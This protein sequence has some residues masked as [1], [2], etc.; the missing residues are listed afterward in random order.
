MPTL[1]EALRQLTSH[2]QSGGVFQPDRTA[3]WVV[4]EATGIPRLELSLHPGR[5]VSPSELAA[6]D[7]GAARLLRGEPLAYVLGT[8]GF[9]GL[10]IRCDSRALIPRPETEELVEQAIRRGGARILD[11]GTG[12]GCVALALAAALPDAEIH[13]LDRSEEALALARENA[14]RLGLAR[15]V[16]FHLGDLREGLPGGPYDGI[17]S[18]PPYVTESEWAELD[19]SVRDYE[20]P[21]ALRGGPDG[22]ELIRAL[23]SAA[24]AAVAPG[25]WL[26]LEIGAAQGPAVLEILEGSGWRR[27]RMLPD[28]AGRDRIAIGDATHV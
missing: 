13:A 21:L 17:V 7:A 28:A 14:E 24:R 15:R 26:A 10:E 8:W 2:L 9:H 22:L 16:R 20:P 12:T 19:R 11:V 1:P 23:A 4:S 6:L 3:A 27:G 25:G 5:P 18:N